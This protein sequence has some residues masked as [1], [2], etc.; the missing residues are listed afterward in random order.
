[1]S[2][3]TVRRRFTVVEY[4]SMGQAGILSE[5]DRVE[6]LEGEVVQ[7]SPIGKRHAAC[8]NRLNRMLSVQVGR[9]AIVSVQNPIRVGVESEPQPD[10][11]L[12]RWRSDF[13]AGA[14]PEAGDA[15]LVVEVA[16][17]SSQTDRL[18][19]VPLYGRGG[20]PEVWL[21][22]LAGDVVEVHRGPGAD[23]YGEVLRVG[24]G[25]HLSPQQLPAL[26]VPVSEIL[27]PEE[28]GD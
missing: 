27:G 25:E 20:V 26:D 10:V 23:G 19:K 28:A 7:K 3:E 16:E 2:V 13:Y 15:Q 18:V 24:R 4:H 12:L 6:L 1:M 8:V 11:A 21:V 9:E 17:S 14:L 5:D 22:D